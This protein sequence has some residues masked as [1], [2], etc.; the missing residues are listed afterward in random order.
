MSSLPL[1]LQKQDAGDACWSFLQTKKLLMAARGHHCSVS[2][3]PDRLAGGQRLCLSWVPSTEPPHESVSPRVSRNYVLELTL[4]ST[5][6][7]LLSYS[8]CGIDTRQTRRVLTARSSLERELD[9]LFVEF[10]VTSRCTHHEWFV[11]PPKY[12]GMGS[13][14]RRA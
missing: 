6:D 14:R 5:G 13:G 9:E 11:A 3:H 7:L 12:Q 2:S 1:S 8:G 10:E 4:C